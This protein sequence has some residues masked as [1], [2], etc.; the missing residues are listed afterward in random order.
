MVSFDIPIALF[1]FKRDKAVEIIQRIAQVQPSRLYLLADYGRNEAEKEQADAC[2]RM[3]EDA[4]TW[5][6]EVIKNYA[7]ENRGVYANIAEGAMWVLRRERWA[8]FL[9]DDNLPEV[10]FFPFCKEMLERYEDDSRILWVCGTNYLG[11][12]RPASGDSYVFTRHMLP[13]GWASWSHKFEKYYDGRLTLLEDEGVR[14]NIGGVY[15]DKR[16]YEQYK[17]SWTG[18]YMRMKHG[19]RPI[20][21]DYQMDFSIKANNLFGICPCRNQIKNIG[22]DEFSIHGGSSFQ[23]KMTRRFCGM[24]S[25]SLTFP[26]QHP[27]A[28]LTDKIFEKKI[29]K[30]MLYPLGKRT[31][32]RF[33]RFVRKILG[34]P[35]GQTT[36]QFLFRRRSERRDGNT[37]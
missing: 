16:L 23:Q 13:C 34:V 1:M 8:I 21:W 10:S 27:K 2:R 29:G 7:T 19:Q 33:L 24:D 32:M 6:C 17:A 18:E 20:S 12:Y 3:V 14:E 9:E 25:Y 11:D 22:V 35:F 5:D 26:L 36:K 37:K 15:S 4:I 31:R 30:I 28:L